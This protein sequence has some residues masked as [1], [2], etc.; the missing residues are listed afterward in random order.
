MILKIKKLVSIVLITLASSLF[1]LPSLA[2]ADVANCTPPLTTQQAI[3]CGVCG[4][5]S[6]CPTSTQ[7]AKSLSDTVAS[8]INVLS[9]VVGIVAVIMIILAGFRYITSGGKQESIASAKNSLI[10]AIVGLVI[11]ALAQLI[12]QFVLNTTTNSGNNSPNNGTNQHG[13][14][15]P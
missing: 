4:V 1:M 5:S 14:T 6:N 10:Y 13:L 15:T 8:V 9:I 11:V 3:N 2:L 12:V 7:S